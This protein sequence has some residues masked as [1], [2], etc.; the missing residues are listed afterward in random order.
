MNVH[1]EILERLDEFLEGALSSAEARRME[2]H[3]RGCP[4]CSEELRRLG[5][6]LDRASALRVREIAP[7]GDLWPG[8]RERLRQPAAP[9]ADQGRLAALRRW[10]SG[11]GRGFTRRPLAWSAAVLLVAA[12]LAIFLAREEGP[13]RSLSQVAGLNTLQSETAQARDDYEAVLRQR[14]GPVPANAGADFQKN[15]RLL[16]QAIAESRAAVERDPRNQGLQRSLLDIYQKELRVLR[17]ATRI[18]QET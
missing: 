17:W 11:L 18:L 13:P 10:T 9:G 5:G 2:E 3:L 12:T 8:I 4:P 6:L 15:L 7:A 14:G 1:R 16:D